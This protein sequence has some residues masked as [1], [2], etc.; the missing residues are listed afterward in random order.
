M[1]GLVHVACKLPGGFMLGEMKIDGCAYERI[2]GAPTPPR[3]GGYAI[4]LNVPAESWEAWA[5]T[6]KNSLMVRRDMVFAD[7]NLATL[8]AKAQSLGQVL[9]G[10]E[11]R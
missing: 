7:A 9:S 6:N 1:S 10:F 11:P 4:T 8:K 3:F 2:A 5:T